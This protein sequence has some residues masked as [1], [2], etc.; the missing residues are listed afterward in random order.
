MNYLERYKEDLRTNYKNNK[1]NI[2][3][4]EDN[5]DIIDFENKI[6]NIN[7]YNV[8]KLLSIENLCIKAN[9]FDEIKNIY[10]I[11]LSNKLIESLEEWDK[12]RLKIKK[13]KTINYII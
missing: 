5:N 12:K 3:E 7:I 9:R 8:E 13:K 4:I 2:K 11:Y 1:F 10:H 6:K